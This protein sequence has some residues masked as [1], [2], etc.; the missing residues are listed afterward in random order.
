MKIIKAKII[1]KDKKQEISVQS[2][3]KRKRKTNMI[4]ITRY[5]VLMIIF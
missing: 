1:N 5:Y 4:N 2:I 3:N